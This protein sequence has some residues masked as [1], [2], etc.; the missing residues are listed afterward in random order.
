MPP[1]HEEGEQTVRIST[2][3]LTVRLPE[4]QTNIFK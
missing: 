2:I 3:R 4:Q 1:L